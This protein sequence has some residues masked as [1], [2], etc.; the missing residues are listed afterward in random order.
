MK[1][2][3]P[4]IISQEFLLTTDLTDIYVLGER[5][6]VFTSKLLSAPETTKCNGKLT[7]T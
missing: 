7:F 5:K 2:I 1:A 4:N 6:P 3:S